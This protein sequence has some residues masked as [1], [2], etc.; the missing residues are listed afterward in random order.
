MP[1]HRIAVL[2]AFYGFVWAFLAAASEPPRVGFVRP[3]SY[4]SEGFTYSY[5]VRVR[6]SYTERDLA[7]ERRKTVW[8]FKWLL[9]AGD[10]ILVAQVN[11]WE[12]GDV[13]R[14]IHPVHV[15]SSVP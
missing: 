15:L 8:E 12:K 2:L 6:V 7:S 13:T 9:P 14:A 5:Y 3:P 4:V 11:G 1:A 10:L